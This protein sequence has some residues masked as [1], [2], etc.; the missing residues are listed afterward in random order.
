L[1]DL[2]NQV[3]ACVTACT[4]AA[5]RAVDVHL[6]TRLTSLAGQVEAMKLRIEDYMSANK[7]VAASIIT[8]LTQQAGTA[9]RAISGAKGDDGLY[10]AMSP[11]QQLWQAIGQDLPALS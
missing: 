4:A 7:S 8:A 1:A 10:Q 11:A 5:E 9:T 6:Q 2:H 3:A